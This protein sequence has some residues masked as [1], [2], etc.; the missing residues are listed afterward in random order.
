MPFLVK[1]VD[2]NTQRTDEMETIATADEVNLIWSEVS[3]EIDLPSTVG[4]AVIRGRV[5]LWIVPVHQGTALRLHCRCSV[6]CVKLN[7]VEAT[8]ELVDP[9]QEIVHDAA[10]IG[11]TEAFDVHLRAS[12]MA[13]HDGG[14]DSDLV[15][16]HNF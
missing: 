8:W 3:L 15:I 16:S 9:L 13:A 5:L 4:N 11:D 10:L 14:N 6:K 12:M 2:P 7:G 1:V